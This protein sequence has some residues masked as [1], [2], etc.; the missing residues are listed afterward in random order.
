[1]SDKANN[2][3]T[4]MTGQV[5]QPRQSL[6]TRMVSAVSSL[7]YS[8][9]GGGSYDGGLRRRMGN[10]GDK[11][12]GPDQNLQTFKRDLNRMRQQIAEN[13]TALRARNYRATALVGDQGFI[14]RLD[15]WPEI[16]DR[17]MLWSE[18]I[19][20][21]AQGENT[22]LG[23]TKQWVN[24]IIGDGNVACRIRE[25]DPNIAEDKALTVNSGTG[26]QL[27][28]LEIDH[29]QTSRNQVEADGSVTINGV[30]RNPR[31]NAI[32]GY[33][34]YRRHPDARIGVPNLV[35][36]QAVWIPA[37]QILMKRHIDRIGSTL[38]SPPNKSIL[39]RIKAKDEFIEAE[40]DR[41]NVSARRTHVLHM[42]NLPDN[43]EVLEAMLGMRPDVSVDGQT[44]AG[45]VVISMPENGEM[46]ALPEGWKLESL[47]PADVGEGFLPFM[48]AVGR[49]IAIG[50]GQPYYAITGDTDGVNE[51]MGRMIDIAQ[52]KDVNFDREEYIVRPFCRPIFKRWLNRLFYVDQIFDPN[53]YDLHA[54]YN[55][56][57]S[58]PKEAYVNRYQEEQAND[59]RLKNKLTTA[60]R[61]MESE[62][63]DPARLVMERAMEAATERAMADPAFVKQIDAVAK[64]RLL[65]Q[66]G[67]VS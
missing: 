27:Q 59:L 18:S 30:N 15:P 35:D 64:E 3:P 62:G 55:V 13:P 6:R 51:R 37:S 43:K 29:L 1:M 7:K 28:M 54:V 11:S 40:M 46:L 2:L 38:S 34:M 39:A 63:E 53:D 5:L 47:D 32:L 21:D 58:Y 12:Y 52:N 31:N 26:I 33:Y 19:E 44:G 42:P 41:K 24:G 20:C 8:F 49:E 57:F 14:P 56:D 16:R 22:M 9:G 66:L 36:N 10:W 25:R 61:I 23:L 67:K 65:K 60:T 48:Q 50:T 4:V 45:D 17:Y